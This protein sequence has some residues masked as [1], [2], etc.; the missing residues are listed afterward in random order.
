MDTVI[1]TECCTIWS[2]IVYTFEWAVEWT[3]EW[4]I[5]CAFIRAIICTIGSTF[6]FT[7]IIRAFSF[8]KITAVIGSIE[9]ITLNPYTL[10]CT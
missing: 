2:T 5:S 8:S 10:S 7:I 6:L 9:L 3:V 4:A 1:G